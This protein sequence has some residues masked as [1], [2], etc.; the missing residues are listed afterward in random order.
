MNNRQ[1]CFDIIDTCCSESNNH[2]SHSNKMILL[3][4]LLNI[5][6]NKKNISVSELKNYVFLKYGW[7]RFWKV[8]QI[9]YTLGIPISRYE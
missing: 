1:F 9:A 7:D 3:N 5:T 4:E 2:L 8:K 6:L